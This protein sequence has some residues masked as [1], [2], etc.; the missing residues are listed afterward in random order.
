MFKGGKLFYLINRLYQGIAGFHNKVRSMHYTY[1]IYM[2]IFIKFSFLRITRN[3]YLAMGAIKLWNRRR[4][5][6]SILGLNSH[7]I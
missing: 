6:H 1:T 5:L 7:C 3:F 2:V 4:N